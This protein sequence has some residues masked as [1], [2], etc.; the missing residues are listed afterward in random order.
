MLHV[1]A[2][3]RGLQFVFAFACMRRGS[4]FM[5]LSVVSG[6]FCVDCFASPP[7][8]RGRSGP[9]NSISHGFPNKRQGGS[10]LTVFP[11]KRGG[12]TGHFSQYSPG[13]MEA[14][15]PPLRAPPPGGQNAPARLAQAGAILQPPQRQPPVHGPWPKPP[16]HMETVSSLGACCLS[17]HIYRYVA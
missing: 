2:F 17:I 13:V 5:G 1:A 3:L 15:D 9:L 4:S 16:K 6:T 10:F 11:T 8:S 7:T 12:V 14:M